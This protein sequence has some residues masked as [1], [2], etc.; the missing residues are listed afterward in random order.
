MEE[1]VKRKIASTIQTIFGLY[2]IGAII[3]ILIFTIFAIVV[4]PPKANSNYQSNY[5]IEG[6]LNEKNNSDSENLFIDLVGLMNEGPRPIVEYNNENKFLDAIQSGWGRWTYDKEL[7]IDSEGLKNLDEN[8][9][10]H[11]KSKLSTAIIHSV[12]YF[13]LCIILCIGLLYLIAKMVEF[14]KK[15]SN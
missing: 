10:I 7:S 1:I 14:V 3:G 15:Y 9:R 13:P 2:V 11:Y 4:K 6:V 12:T 8:R 5:P